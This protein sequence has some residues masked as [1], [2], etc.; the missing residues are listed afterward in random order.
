MLGLAA[1]A[2]PSA[3][4]QAYRRLFARRWRPAAVEGARNG[5]DRDRLALDARVLELLEGAF[6][7][8]TGDVA[9]ELRHDDGDVP[10]PSP[11]EP[12]STL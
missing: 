12:V 6:E 2:H 5:D 3:T 1:D 4:M 7:Q 11:R 10:T 9:V 8:A